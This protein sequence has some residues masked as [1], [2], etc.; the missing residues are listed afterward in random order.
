MPLD[1][2]ITLLN[3]DDMIH[4]CQ[5]IIEACS[6]MEIPLDIIDKWVTD[7]LR[8]NLKIGF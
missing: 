3:Y 8:Q 5:S 2:T 1:I 6:L 4:D 7:Y